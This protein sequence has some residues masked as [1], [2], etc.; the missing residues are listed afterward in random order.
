MVEVRRFSIRTGG[1]RPRSPLGNLLWLIILLVI[2]VFVVAAV[3]T[4]L[5]PLLIIA[6][7]IAVILFIYVKIRSWTRSAHDPNG[8]LDGRR[9]VRVIDRDE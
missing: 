3:L 1:L 2:V 4:I 9:N 7:V 6:A 8:M 5:V